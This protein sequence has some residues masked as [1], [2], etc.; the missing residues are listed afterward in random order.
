ME[1]SYL[2]LL[3]ALSGLVS[4]LFHAVLW[5]LIDVVRPAAGADPKSAAARLDIPDIALHVA[6][7]TGLG[8]LFWLSWG[9]AALV[10]VPWWLRGIAFGALAWVCIGLPAI[11]SLARAKSG[12]AG[13]T[14][15]VALQWATTCFIVGLACSWSWQRAM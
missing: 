1:R 14:S 10:D 11:I 3:G 2:L 9:L 8:L 15:V 12:A 13:A 6:S 5:S 4:V 7:G